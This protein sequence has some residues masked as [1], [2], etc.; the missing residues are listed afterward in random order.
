MEN[1][2]ASMPIWKGLQRWWA[3]LL[4]T[5]LLL[6]HMFWSS[7][8]HTFACHH[9]C[10]IWPCTLW[11]YWW[12]SCV[13]DALPSL[14]AQCPHFWGHQNAWWV[15]SVC[16]LHA[17]QHLSQLLVKSCLHLAVWEPDERVHD[18]TH[19]FSMEGYW[20]AHPVL[21]LE[22]CIMPFAI[23]TITWGEIF[24]MCG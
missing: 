17:Y 2:L 14:M 22:F 4:Q 15:P 3:V 18:I 8:C 13:W 21:Q 6:V 9:G 7:W 1:L 23:T 11:F 10:L 5:K 19:C 12:S 20:I 24:C 16:C